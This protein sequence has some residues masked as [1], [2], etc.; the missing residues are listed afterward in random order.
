MAKPARPPAPASPW[1]AGELAL[2]ERTGR[3]EALAGVGARF[4]RDH[5]TEEHREFF[6]LLPFLVLGAVD[7]AGQP[8]ASLVTGAPGFAHSPDPRRL[9]IDALPN[10]SDPIARQIAPGQPFA[11]LGIQ[12]HTRRRNRLNGPI[13]AVDATGFTL[14]VSQSFGNCPKYVHARRLEPV[15][16]PGV[17]PAVRESDRLSDT[18]RAL[19]ARLDTFYIASANL[20]EDAGRGRGVDVSHR[21][22]PPGFVRMDDARTLTTPDYTG[23]F[24]FNTLGN[25]ALD[26]RAGL[27]FPDLE[28]GERVL[29]AARAEIVFDGPELEAFPAAQRLLRFHVT[30]VIRL[31]DGRGLRVASG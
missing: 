30:R 2:Q 14:G 22:G 17:T 23:N 27:L 10:D 15:P 13:E 26:P 12:P 5:L 16:L 28:S 18:D 6:P 24:F 3:R 7:A 8:W 21:G 25:L 20:R 19:L 9:R 4:V 11:V 1:H 31:A 29:V